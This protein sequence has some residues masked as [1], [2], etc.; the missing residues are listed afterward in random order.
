MKFGIDETAPFVK[1][2][3]NKR[4]TKMNTIV[5]KIKKSRSTSI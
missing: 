5:T 2:E 4:K 3:N 1:K